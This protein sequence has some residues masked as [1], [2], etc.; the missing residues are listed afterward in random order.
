MPNPGCRQAGWL[1]PVSWVSQVC[2]CSAVTFPL[3]HPPSRA[4]GMAVSGTQAV[5][6]RGWEL[7]CEASPCDKPCRG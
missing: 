4:G 7:W 2:Q 5:S 1:Q 3:S 6:H